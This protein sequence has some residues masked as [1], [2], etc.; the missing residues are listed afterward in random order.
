MLTE[1]AAS[2]GL[3]QSELEN[4]RVNYC[5]DP[6]LS[7][8]GCIQGEITSSSLTSTILKPKLN[9]YSG[10]LTPPMFVDSGELMDANGAWE[11]RYR[12]HNG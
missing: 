2:F 8:Y 6:N 9:F 3:N 12:I 10:V 7:Q 5:K 1:N 11:N 4:E